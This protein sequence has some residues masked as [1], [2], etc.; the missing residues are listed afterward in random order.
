MK[1]VQT[2]LQLRSQQSNNIITNPKDTILSSFNKTTSMKICTTLGYM[3][4]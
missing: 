2:Q 4:H 3:F 1:I